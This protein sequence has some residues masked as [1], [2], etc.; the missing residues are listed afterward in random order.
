MTSDSTFV[1]LLRVSGATTWGMA[2]KV[3]VN[4]TAANEVNAVAVKLARSAG[5][6]SASIVTCSSGVVLAPAAS[7]ICT[8]TAAL[9][10]ADITANSVTLK[11][12]ATANA[13]VVPTSRQ[14]SETTVTMKV[15]ALRVAVTNSTR[16]TL[17]SGTIPLTITLTNTG[18]V[19]L[20]NVTL[21]LPDNVTLPGGSPCAVTIPSI[22]V[23][24]AISCPATL[25]ITPEVAEGNSNT[26]PLAFTAN[27]PTLQAPVITNV[28]AYLGRAALLSITPSIIGTITKQGGCVHLQGHSLCLHCACS[29]PPQ[30]LL[31]LSL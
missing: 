27:S 30:H 25:D 10:E 9:D 19:A 14:A 3:T 17:Q 16:A 13:A 26:L 2:C 11:A 20:I 21:A 18:P 1:V 6:G 24:A 23:G 8:V 28:N 29:Q 12:G 22:A 31:Q 7:R 15:A 4:N 5:F